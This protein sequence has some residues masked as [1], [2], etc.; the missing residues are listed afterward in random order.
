MHKTILIT[1]ATDG[2]GLE[3]ARMLAQQGHHILIHGR[4]PAKLNKVKTGLSRLCKNAVIDSYI[5]DFSSLAEVKTLAQQI[6]DKHL[7][8]DVLINNAGVYKVSEI[9]TAENLDVRF[10]VNTIAPYL[11]TQKLLPLFDA[12]S[13][14]VNLSSAAQAPVDLDALISPNAGELD[15]PVYAQSKLALTMWSIELA[16]TLLDK[17]TAIIPVNPASFLGSKLVK[18]A[19]GVD[20]NDLAIGADIL[21][22]AALSDEFANASGQYF[23]NDSGL[24]KDPHAD[25]LNPAK[26]RKLVETLD[27]L[28]KEKLCMAPS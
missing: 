13:R 9:T 18:D 25:A 20:G 21:C 10:V 22:R 14:I 15:G 2:I 7:Q 4:N 17:G 11:L 12:T 19:Y 23:D 16:N 3:T 24:F 1:G 26:N 8:L 6:R 5:A 27:R 28:L